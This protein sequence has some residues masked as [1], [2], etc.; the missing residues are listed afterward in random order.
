MK[1]K[2][3][4]SCGMPLSEPNLMGTNENQTLNE[5]YCIFCYKGGAFTQ[6]VTMD[7]M[8]LHCA[9]FVDEINKERKQNLTKEEAIAQMKMFFPQLKRWNHNR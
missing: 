6:D 3:C 1:Q 4:Q 9:Q 8:I 7:E 5:E 2:L